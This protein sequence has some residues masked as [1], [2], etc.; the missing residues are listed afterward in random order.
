MLLPLLASFR[1]NAD[2]GNGDGDDGV[3]GLGGR[4]GGGLGCG[5]GGL[6]GGLGG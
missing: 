4:L 3:G 5:L 6:K 2:A 1:L